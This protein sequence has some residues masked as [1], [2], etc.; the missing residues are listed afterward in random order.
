MIFVV[1][2]CMYSKTDDVDLQHRASYGFWIWIWICNRISSLTS[3][4]IIYIYTSNFSS[5]RLSISPLSR[6]GYAATICQ[7]YTYR[8]NHHEMLYVRFTCG[9]QHLYTMIYVPLS[10]ML[11]IYLLNI[12]FW[13]VC[14]Y[15]LCV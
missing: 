13:V 10:A 14:R 1:S 11:Y 8:Q 6:C 12:L 3:P 9:L 2:I 4:H 15:A 7:L 5:R